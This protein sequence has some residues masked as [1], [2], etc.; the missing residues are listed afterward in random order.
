MKLGM[1]ISDLER[2]HIFIIVEDPYLNRKSF[3]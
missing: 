1:L 3:S 2:L